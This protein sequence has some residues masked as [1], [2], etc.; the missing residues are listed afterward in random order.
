MGVTRCAVGFQ[1]ADG[2]TH[3][4]QVDAESV[5]EAATRGLVAFQ[6]HPWLK[7]E[8]TLATLLLVQPAG[9][10]RAHRVEVRRLLAWFDGSGRDR[11]RRFQL[12][13]LLERPQESPRVNQRLRAH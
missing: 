8:L 10:A 1:S 9:P 5:Y 6:R 7:A 4:V 11:A 2:V 3:S 13:R 12:K